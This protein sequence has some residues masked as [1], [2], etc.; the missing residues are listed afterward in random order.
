VDALATLF[1]NYMKATEPKGVVEGSA[2]AAAEA[3]CAMQAAGWRGDLP[4]VA[5]DFFRRCY[6]RRY[7]TLS[8]EERDVLIARY[9]CCTLRRRQLR[10]VGDSG[11]DNFKLG[12]L[13]LAFMQPVPASEEFERTRVW[14]KSR[15]DSHSRSSFWLT[16]AVT[17]PSHRADQPPAVVCVDVEDG[18]AMIRARAAP[19]VRVQ[20]GGLE[21][22]VA[23]VHKGVKGLKAVKG[24]HVAASG[25]AQASTGAACVVEGGGCPEI[26]HGALVPTP[27]LASVPTSGS[28]SDAG[29]PCP[30]SPP[31]KFPLVG[32]VANDPDSSGTS[33]RTASLPCSDGDDDPAAEVIDADCNASKVFSL[34]VG[35][36]RTM[37]MV[38]GTPMDCKRHEVLGTG[39]A[40]ATVSPGTHSLPTLP[41]K[42]ALITGITGQV[43]RFTTSATHSK[44]PLQLVMSESCL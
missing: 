33:S 4:L 2:A 21:V 39:A 18:P 13:E 20:F 23:V 25:Q 32:C 42:I 7:P 19:R 31:R 3:L 6:V 24:R 28:S 14:Y 41:S 15:L 35:M 1:H 10:G 38:L 29:V 16:V 5:R 22:P 37:H 12:R 9:F 34:P 44:H 27:P 17:H 26:A 36:E 11:L 30:G 43:R 40:E 8:D